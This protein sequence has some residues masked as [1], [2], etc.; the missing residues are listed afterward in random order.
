MGG[1]GGRYGVCGTGG[2]V[3]VVVRMVMDQ[4]VI[5]ASVRVED[6]SC[7]ECGGE[8]YGGCGECGGEDW[9]LW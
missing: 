2:M 9:W 7:G 6:A 1:C 8:S 5:V 4:K 3:V